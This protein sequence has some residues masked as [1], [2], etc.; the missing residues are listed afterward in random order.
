MGKITL[1]AQYKNVALEGSEK[2]MRL[3]ML[4]SEQFDKFNP[5]VLGLG[6]ISSRSTQ[7]E[8]RIWPSPNIS[9]GF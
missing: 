1:E 2:R 7:L 6:D 5:D 9:A 3:L 8:A 4:T